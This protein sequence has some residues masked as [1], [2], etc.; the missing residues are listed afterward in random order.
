MAELTIYDSQGNKY[1][2]RSTGSPNEKIKN[3]FFGGVRLYA[4]IGPETKLTVFFRGSE[5]VGRAEQYYAVYKT[6]S[7]NGLFSQFKSA[8]RRSVE[9]EFNLKIQTAS[10]D[11][12]VF[13]LLD[14]QNNRLPGSDF[15]HVV[16]DRAL[17][18]G[19]TLR[20]GVGSADEALGVL[21]RHFDD[22]AN[23]VAIAENT[24]ITEL[25]DCDLAIEIGSY[26]GLQPLGQ[27]KQTLD[28][29]RRQFEGQFIQ[30]KVSSIKKDVEEIRRKTNASDKQI[31]DRLKRDLVIFE[32]PMVTTN[33]SD[34]GS[35]LRQLGR[36]QQIG[37]AV[38]GF[39]LIV[40]L[41]AIVGLNAAAM[42]GV[43]YPAVADPVVVI[44]DDS[45]AGDQNETTED[46][47]TDD[48]GQSTDSD[49]ETTDAE[50]EEDPPD[51]DGGE[52][53]T[54]DGGEETTD[55]GGEETTDD[56]GEETTDDGGE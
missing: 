30:Q 4:Q 39:A 49:E 31:R 22:G 33:R 26:T 37:A 5:S 29:T 3:L 56:G 52:E 9:D 13:E 21:R 11:V 6:R 25:K 36:P 27:T 28:Q 43:G 23:E 19:Q 24:D 18:T 20:F 46:Q 40:L 45:A 35:T 44:G 1:G 51:E 15:E 12:E 2:D 53:T 41:L 10:K 50:T 34:E 38:V 16:I 54:D 7:T 55:D 42:V 47:T 48:D 14:D 8:L 32:T 17:S